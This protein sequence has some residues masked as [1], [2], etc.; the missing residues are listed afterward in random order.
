MPARTS[1]DEVVDLL[2]AIYPES[3]YFAL[4]FSV[5]SAGAYNVLWQP[6]N[7]SGYASGATAQ[8][9]YDYNDP[10][11]TD[12]NGPVTFDASTST[13]NRTAHGYTDGM[14]IS[15]ASII[16]T[17]GIIQDQQYYVVN[18]TADTFQVSDTVGGTALFLIGN[19]T[20]AI[21]PYKQVLVRVIPITPA[22]AL[23]TSV[24]L[25]TKNTTTGLGTYVQPILDTTISTGCTTLTLGTASNPLRLM[26]RCTILRH[27]T[28]NMAN[29]FYNCS[30][31]QSVPLFNTTNVTSMGAASAGMFQGC[32]SLQTVPLF[33]TSNVVSMGPSAATGGGMFKDCAALVTVP[34][35]NTAKVTAMGFMFNGCSALQS[36]PL[37]DTSKV[38]YTGSMFNGCSA[39]QSVPLFDT[40]NVTDT[41]SMF[42]QCK[43]LQTVPVFDTTKVTSMSSM[44]NACSSLK[45]VPLFNTVNVTTMTSMFAGCNILQSVPPFNTIKVTTF[46]TMF[47]SCISLQSV[48]AFDTTAVTGTTAFNSMFS[49]CIALQQIPDMN[50]NRAAI[51]TNASYNGMFS[52]CVSLSKIGNGAP[53]TGPKFTFTVASCKLSA[54]AL[55]LLY[56]SLPTVTGQTITVTGN[57]GIAGDDP[58]IATLKGW[59]VSGS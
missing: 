27:N 29:T 14:R 30:S 35:F 6:T 32:S 42:S 37:F 39:L 28:T 25:T 56:T 38:T 51:T 45:S 8:H 26:E 10:D 59:T 7:N 21:L 18:A 2:V 53:D 20:G 11:F 4:N 55:N 24:N 33:D 47:N 16:T 43:S 36:V 52:G 54:N 49:G 31:L 1:A 19:G 15:F 17:T 57:V 3:N 22:G 48:P 44:F 40:A 46:S 34:L 5:S 12:T 58:S 9:F 23:L 50:F 41:T 13:V